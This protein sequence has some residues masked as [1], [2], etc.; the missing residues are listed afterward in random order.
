MWLILTKVTD[1]YLI[2]FFREFKT[3]LLIKMYA[4]ELLCI[5]KGTNV[6]KMSVQIIVYFIIMFYIIC[7]ICGKYFS[8]II[9]L[10]YVIE[11][12]K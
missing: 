2:H 5:N 11:P 10:D 1:K 3:I 9:T 12:D 4:E 6:I 7:N 8:K